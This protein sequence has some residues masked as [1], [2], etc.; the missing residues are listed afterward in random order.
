MT[1]TLLPDRIAL[2]L[3]NQALGQPL[4]D[5]DRRLIGSPL[6]RQYKIREVELAAASVCPLAQFE[7]LT[8]HS[9]D[10]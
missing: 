5:A 3:A 9:F 8:G 7:R 6:A 4:T 10:R 1:R 2:A